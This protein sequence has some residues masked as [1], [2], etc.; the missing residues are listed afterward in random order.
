MT[1]LNITPDS[2][3]SASRTC[4]LPLIERRVREALDAG[5]DIIDV[6]GYSSRPGAGDVD[7][8]EEWKR[9]RMGL[10]VVRALS[11]SVIL[12]VDTFRAKVAERA[13]EEFGDVIIN[14]IS[15][16]N[17]DPDMISVAARHDVPY[18]AM[19]MRGVPSSMQQMTQYEDIVEEVV[20]FFDH[21]I[22]SLRSAGLRKENIILDA[23]FG[24]A[25]TLEQNYELLA[26]MHRLS[27]M[28]YRVL[29][30]V[31]RKSMIYKLLGIQAE[32]A[33]NGTTALNWECLRQGASILRVHD[34]RQAVET[35]KLYEAFERGAKK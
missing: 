30:G 9:V 16:G 13:I 23:G 33:L 3:Y 31:S 4:E 32:E 8:E 29:A 12:S 17:I 18:V 19:H 34:T 14:D 11:K 27:E 26:G 20:E 7:V 28:G 10:S 35:I 15:A 24:F 25:K 2:F 6:G 21:K 22:H 1:I 5:C